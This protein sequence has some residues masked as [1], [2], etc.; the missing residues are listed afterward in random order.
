MSFEDIS[1]IRDRI[2]SGSVL[3]QHS[4]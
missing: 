1:S 3:T 4:S 2:L